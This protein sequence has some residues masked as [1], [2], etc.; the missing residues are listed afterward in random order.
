LSHSLFLLGAGLFQCGNKS[1]KEVQ[2]ANAQAKQIHFD[3][4]AVGKVQLFEGL[5]ID[6]EANSW[7]YHYN[8]FR[9]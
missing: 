8:Y 3:G 9:K 5:L 1:A 2:Q 7:V 6:L 4:Y